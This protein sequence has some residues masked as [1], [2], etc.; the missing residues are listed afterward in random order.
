MVAS[1]RRDF[2]A[3]VTTS[4][5]AFTVTG[6][7]KPLPAA[8]APLPKR[9]C[10]DIESCREEGERRVAEEDAL[11]GP[12]VNMGQGVRYRESRRGTGPALK[13]GDVCEVTYEVQKSNGDYMWSLGR[14]KEPGKRDLGE[15]YRVVLG[16][17]DV[18]VAV[19]MAL[20][21]MQKGG[22][23]KIEMPPNLGF[24]TSKNEAPP[25]PDNFSGQKKYERYLAL[26]SGNGLQPGYQ[27][28]LIFE[29]ELVKI[30]DK[31]GAKA[32]EGGGGLE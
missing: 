15:T 21:G 30:R 5:A 26:L 11:L 19:E 2:A 8:A 18:P 7:S 16:K 32:A 20:E 23:R 25:L 22:V 14:D 3:A 31:K 29:V 12:I 10:T 4:G 27:A 17:H 6:G 13:V 24:E 1:S 28:E 9:K